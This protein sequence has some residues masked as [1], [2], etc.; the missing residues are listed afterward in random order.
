MPP[1]L[2]PN[3]PNVV[4]LD[5]DS[6]VMMPGATTPVKSSDVIGFQSAFTKKMQALSA[7]QA[8]LEAATERASGALEFVDG[9]NTD[10]VGS[11]S[12]L[13]DELKTWAEQKGETVPD[14]IL[15]DMTPTMPPPANSLPPQTQG[16]SSQ[17]E[18]QMNERLAN[19]ETYVTQFTAGSAAE[20][21][22]GNLTQK[23]PELYADQGFRGLV[24]EVTK[25]LP[26]A[27]LEDA[28]KVAA[29]DLLSMQNQTLQNELKQVRRDNLGTTPNLG[30]GTSTFGA[31]KGLSPDD[32]FE[33]EFNKL[34]DAQLE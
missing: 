12:K 13:R 21:E 24:G 18:K 26:G 32:L 5:E 27:P 20:R 19:M 17:F 25:R 28:H 6:L 15:N 33:S 22:L 4:I 9:F 7:Q 1:Q 11:I 8:A 14:W 16:L 23:H 34:A 10:P 29:Y 2:D 3:N 30:F 31:K